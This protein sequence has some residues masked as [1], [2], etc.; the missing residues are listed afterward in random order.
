MSECEC[1]WVCI[2]VH[3]VCQVNQPTSQRT[4]RTLAAFLPT[5]L[6]YW[7]FN[8]GRPGCWLVGNNLYLDSW[9]LILLYFRFSF[10]ALSV[11]FVAFGRIIRPCSLCTHFSYFISSCFNSSSRFP[12]VLVSSILNV[13]DSISFRA[14]RTDCRWLLNSLVWDGYE[15]QNKYYE[16]VG[17][18]KLSKPHLLCW[19][20]VL[21][22]FSVIQRVESI[23]IS[24]IPSCG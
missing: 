12:I 23:V 13:R 24:T 1:G 9:L 10:R 2:H 11:L 18:Y 3:P 4:L 22:R 6:R 16:V 8:R 20:R 14:M 17:M 19:Q 15:I 21:Q 7:A 5:L